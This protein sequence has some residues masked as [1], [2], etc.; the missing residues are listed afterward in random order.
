MGI[1]VFYSLLFCTIL[2]NSRQFYTITFF[3]PLFCTILYYSTILHYSLQFTTV[4]HY[5]RLFF[6]CSVLFFTFFLLILYYSGFSFQSSLLFS[7]I[8]YYT[9]LYYPSLFF[10]IL[11]W[12][13]GLARESPRVSQ[14]H[15]VKI[16]ARFRVRVWSFWDALVHMFHTTM[17]HRS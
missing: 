16:L 7:K 12:P 3:A 1:I 13:Q 8:L 9:I 11:C 17:H 10:T 6:Q 15:F 2:Q 5:S 4:L 14:H